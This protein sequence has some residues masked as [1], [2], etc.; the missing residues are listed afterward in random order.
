MKELFLVPDLTGKYHAFDARKLVVVPVE[1]SINVA[2]DIRYYANNRIR[3]FFFEN[4][5]IVTWNR[6][7]PCDVLDNKI[8]WSSWQERVTP[9]D[10][11]TR[12]RNAGIAFSFE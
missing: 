2:C 6:R 4:N 1:D 7:I 11:C 3:D 5:M 10:V 8:I 12:L 9:H